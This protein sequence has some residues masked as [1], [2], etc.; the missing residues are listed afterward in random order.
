MTD[1]IAY[2]ILLIR[3][4][5]EHYS[6]QVRQAY[7]YLSRYKGIEFIDECYEA[8][9]LLSI[10]DAIEDVSRICQNNGGNLSYA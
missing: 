10:D 3:K 8:E 5:A 9:H 7:Q 2:S 4:F 1:K 6:L